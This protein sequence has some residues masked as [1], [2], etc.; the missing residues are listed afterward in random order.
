[1]RT[2]LTALLVVGCL[3]HGGVGAQE[4][5]Q[6]GERIRVE[7]H[8]DGGDPEMVEGW[9]VGIHPGDSIVLATRADRDRI[10]FRTTLVDRFQ[11]YRIDTK[12]TQVALL[13]TVAG[14]LIMFPFTESECSDTRTEICL[15][16]VTVL[17][18]AAGG[19]LLGGLIGSFFKVP[20]WKDVAPESFRFPLVQPALTFDGGVG[21][22][23]RVALPH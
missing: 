19:F 1:M 3:W 16:R 13:G 4:R 8:V 5:V 15:G 11:V 18:A 12:V 6:N 9:L 14:G 17:Y 22:S 2:I 23:A 7:H 10:S 20:T 21:F